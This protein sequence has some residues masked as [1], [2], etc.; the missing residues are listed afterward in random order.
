M[1]DFSGGIPSLPGTKVEINAIESLTRANNWRV[2]KYMEAEAN[3]ILIDSLTAPNILHIATHGFF[4]TYNAD[5]KL[6]GVENQ[7]NEENPLLRSGILLS[8]ASIGL[9]G[10]LPYENSFEDGLL[11]AYETMNLNLEGTELVVLSACETGLGDV[12]NGEGVYGL[13]RAFLVAGA[14]NLIMSLWTVNDY[15]TQL[16]M[17]EFYKHWTEGDD[18]FV[19]FRKAQMKI[20]EEFPQPYYWAAFTIIGE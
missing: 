15:T 10:G 18:K 12:K 20:K 11:T 4:K 17:T 14:E 13:Q 9:A 6:S 5:K 2:S 8:G 7:G 3:E 16:L 19:A 1:R